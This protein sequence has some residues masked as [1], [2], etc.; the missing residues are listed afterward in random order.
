MLT[1]IR[2]AVTAAVLA[3]ALA[4]CGASA[5]DSGGTLKIGYFRGAVAGPESIVAANADL[6]G[7]VPAKLELRPI[8]SGVAGLAQLRAGAFPVVSAVGNPPFVGAIA[9]GTDVKVVFAESLDQSGLAVNDEIRNP[10][11]LRK[12]GVLVG[13]TLDFQLRGWLKS[14]NLTAKVQVVSFASEAAEAA[15][16]KSGKID[17]VYISQAYLPELQRHK[18][19]VLVSAA[20][21]AGLGYA[22]V[23]LLAVSTPY[24]RDNPDVVQ[25]LVCQISKAQTLAKSPQAERYIRPA[26]RF[27]GVPPQDVVAA[28][29][30]YPY[31]PTAEQSSWLKGADGTPASG[32]LVQN[33]RLTAEFLVTQGRAKSVP[34][35]GQI[36]AH[37]DP[38]YWDKAQAGGCG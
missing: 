17:A 21:I 34:P 16:W 33:F 8:D 19:R 23:N 30:A 22:A 6:A 28:T 12:V 5:G 32:R 18:A 35:V 29:K 14:Q 10:G 24:A 7:K 2:S 25:N 38:Q 27:L 4:G 11:D 13:S 26:A 9:T 20:D 1:T 37:V 36:A 15:A 31:I 3:A